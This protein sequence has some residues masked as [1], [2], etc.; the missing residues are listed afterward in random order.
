MKKNENWVSEIL[1][2]FFSGPK[3]VQNSNLVPEKVFFGSAHLHEPTISANFNK[4]RSYT[5]NNVHTKPAPR[6][7]TKNYF[8]GVM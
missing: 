1:S 5:E 6:L 3:P 7:D 4:F 8:D 2:N